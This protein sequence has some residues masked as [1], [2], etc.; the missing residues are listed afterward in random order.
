MTNYVDSDVKFDIRDIPIIQNSSQEPSASSKYYWVLD[1]LLLMF[2][3]WKS[4]YNSRITYRVDS[5]CKIWYQRWPSPPKF[6]SGTI[7]ILQVWLCPWYT[8]NHA[9][10]LK[11]GI[12]LNN[13][14]WWLFMMSNKIP[15]M[16]KSSKPP[17]RN[18][19]HPPSM[20]VFLLHL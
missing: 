1:V 9:R 6:Q 11:I 16:T 17:V 20:T 19:Q 12:Q 13:D 7:S 2:G 8:F 5:P 14:T 18:H 10:D 15:N 3:R 4:A